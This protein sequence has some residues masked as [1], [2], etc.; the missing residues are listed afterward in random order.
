M[1]IL[2]YHDVV[3]REQEESS[4]FAGADAAHYKLSPEAF[5]DHV[6]RVHR[7]GSDLLF[8]FDDGG[9][10]AMHIADTLEGYGLR[11]VFFIPSRYVGSPGFCTAQELRGLALRG[12][13]IGSHSASHPVPISALSDEALAT[14]WSESRAALRDTI[15]RDILSASVPGGFTSMRVE[16]TAAAAGYSR[17]YTS[18]PTRRTRRRGSMEIYG[19]FSITRA[20]SSQTISVLASGAAW[21]WL[22]QSSVWTTKKAIKAIGGRHWLA[23]R[24]AYFRLRAQ[25]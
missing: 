16:Q 3:P 17:L 7:G 22:Y 1:N 25:P 12:H 5:A 9:A 8:S 11:G 18:E 23:L 21:P 19:R 10:S 13:E 20:T 4:G 24:K 15:G 2:L 14:E 6:S